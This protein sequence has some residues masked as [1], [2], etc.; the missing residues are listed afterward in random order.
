MADQ[1]M[2]SDSRDVRQRERHVKLNEGLETDT[3]C[4]Q[5]SLR[6]ARYA[7]FIP[8]YRHRVRKESNHLF[9]K[10]WRC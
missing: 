10:A 5:W 9:A 1:R 8:N 7:K 4:R 3:V 2:S 6:V